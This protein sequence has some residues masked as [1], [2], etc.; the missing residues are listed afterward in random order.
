L[1]SSV[2]ILNTEQ[3]T[4]L[5]SVLLLLFKLHIYHCVQLNAALLS[6]AEQCFIIVIQAS[7]LP[8]CTIKCCSVVFGVTL[9]L[10]VINTSP[11]INKLCHLPASNVI[12]LPWSVVAECIALDGRSPHNYVTSS[13]LIHD[14]CSSSSRSM[15]W[16][17][18]LAEIAIFAYPTCI[19]RPR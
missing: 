13:T 5:S 8:L 6:S 7:Y 12:N 14:I 19:R 2:V 1:C 9:T 4:T 3:C 18:I 11:T 15:R 17:Q 10:L 16:S